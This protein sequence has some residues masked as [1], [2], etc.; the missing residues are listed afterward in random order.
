VWILNQPSKATVQQF[1]HIV[2]D[3]VESSDQASMFYAAESALAAITDAAHQRDG[4]EVML[5]MS[6]RF[7][8]VVCKRLRGGVNLREDE[9]IVDEDDTEELYHDEMPMG[10]SQAIPA[11]AG[12][13][14]CTSN[15]NNSTQTT[16]THAQTHVCVILT[17]A[18]T[19]TQTNTHTHTHTHT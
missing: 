11:F 18:R 8:E 10:A 19:H 7:M 5:S 15:D 2:L 12:Y 9:H 14:S 13:R 1:V 6:E 17:S 16:G 3:L 4:Q